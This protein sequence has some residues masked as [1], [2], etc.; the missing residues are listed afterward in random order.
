M[1][2]KI[3]MGIIHPITLKDFKDLKNDYQSKNFEN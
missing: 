1:A 2:R 3:C